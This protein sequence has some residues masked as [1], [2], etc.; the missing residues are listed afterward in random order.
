MYVVAEPFGSMFAPRSTASPVRPEEASPDRDGATG[1]VVSWTA[2]PSDTSPAALR[3][4]R[5]KL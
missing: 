1:L 5:Q 4:S 2:G 3:A